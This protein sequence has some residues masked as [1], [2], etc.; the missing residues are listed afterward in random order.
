MPG[1]LDRTPRADSGPN[2]KDRE[3]KKDE[4]LKGLS[5]DA[6]QVE[7]WYR[8]IESEIVQP[9][10]VAIQTKYFWKRWAPR[11]GPLPTCLLIR[12]RQYCYFNRATGERRDWCYP[13]QEQLG[14]EIGAHRETVRLA[15]RHLEEHGFV[16]RE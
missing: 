4:L 12:L 3:R 11:L 5:F 6:I 10:Q 15:L 14:L 16:R 8:T 2:E 1:P 7:P 9:D 13:S